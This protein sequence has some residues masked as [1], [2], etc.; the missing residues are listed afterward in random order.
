MT[1]GELG[2][3]ALNGIFLVVG[4]ALLYGLGLVR[5]RRGD[6]RLVGLAYLAGWALI[7]SALSFALML[8]IGTGVTT[9]VLIGAALTC[10]GVVAGRRR[11]LARDEPSPARE[12]RPMHPVGL[13]VAGIA[14]AVLAVELAGAIVVSVTNDWSTELDVLAAWLPRAG[15]IFYSHQLNPSVWNTFIAPW[16][17][18]LVPTM[19]AGT[20]DFSGGFH[21]SALPLQEVLLGIAFL[22]AVIG[23]VDRFTPRWV[24]LPPLALL[25]TT[26]WFWWRLQ[27]LLPDQ[28]LSYLLSAA[29]L[30]SM[31]WLY[32]RHRAWLGLALVFLMAASLTKVE[33]VVFGSLLVAVVLAAAFVR[34]RRAGRP[35]LVL[36]LGPA[37]I[38]PWH[39]WLAQHQVPTSTSDYNAPHLLSPS[40][41]A[42][43]FG[44][45]TYALDWMLGVGVGPPPLSPT[46]TM[47]WVSIGVAL[48]VCSRVPVVSGAASAWLVLSFLGLCTIYWTGRVNV[49]W[50]VYWTANR[51]GT[52]II[53]AAI[54]LTPLLL[55]LA[56]SRRAAPPETPAALDA[57][58]P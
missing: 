57:D 18:P 15:T 45:F 52:T 35:A 20:F 13:A 40:F 22:L 54:T 42:D 6:L 5:W 47:I 17:P 4:Y 36:L 9:T 50:Y 12:R 2:L 27:S 32:E 23:I 19:Y 39:L 26:P 1:R 58:V 25:V 38:V 24:S 31:V 7:G 46:P 37:A 34:Y 33:G 8:G 30:A 56:L 10:G 14:A 43:R 48:A 21:P 29:A 11:G 55:G 16:Y 28:T 51:V 53:I 41:L 3:V 44:R 49:H